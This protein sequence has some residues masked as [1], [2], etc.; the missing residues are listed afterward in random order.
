MPAPKVLADMGGHYLE[1]R[2]MS[3]LHEHSGTAGTPVAPC[4]LHNLTRAAGCPTCARLEHEPG[5][6]DLF[7]A[8][9][10]DELLAAVTPS[11]QDLD[12]L[13]AEVSTATTDE[14]LAELLEGGAA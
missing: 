6:V 13:L 1:K 7:T 5:T 2:L 4:H 11:P 9:D 3:T 10:L 14:L 12:E 8:A